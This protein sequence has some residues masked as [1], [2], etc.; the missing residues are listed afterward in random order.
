VRARVW[1]SVCQAGL[2]ELP[3]LVREFVPRVRM[4]EVQVSKAGGD[5]APPF[6]QAVQIGLVVLAVPMVV[7][8]FLEPVVLRLGAAVPGLFQMAALPVLY[9]L[10]VV[11]LGLLVALVF[12][13]EQILAAL[14][15]RG[16][17]ALAARLFRG[18]LFL[19]DLEVPL[20][21]ELAGL[22]LDLDRLVVLKIP[23]VPEVLEAGQ[24]CCLLFF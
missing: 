24:T 14:V 13:G 17:L 21:L 4:R 11:L 1:G 6:L 10:E 7:Q 22:W 23:G 16:V 12:P 20:F 19:G 3:H 18:A 15:V 2:E 9:L 8:P 5:Q